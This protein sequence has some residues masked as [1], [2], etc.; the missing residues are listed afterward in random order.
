M[1]KRPYV[2]ASS[3]ALALAVTGCGGGGGASSNSGGGETTKAAQENQASDDSG[4]DQADNSGQEA[5]GSADRDISC[6]ITLATWDVAAAKT[7]DELDLEGRFQ[8]LYPNV[9]IDIEE[10]NAEPEYFNSMKIRS[11]AS[12][13]PDLMF[14]KSDSMNQY[15]E[16]L[17]DL[18]D[19]AANKD[20]QIASEYA[21]D[22]K[23]YGIPDRKAN[24]YVYYWTDLFEE[25][26]VSVPET[27]DEFVQVSETLQQHFGASD[28]EFAAICMGAKDAWPT[29]PL[30]EYGPASES[31]DGYYWDF[32]TTEDAPFAE[33]TAIR[34]VYTKIFNLF[35]KGVLGADPLGVT[36]DQ[37]RALFAKKKGAMVLNSPMFLTA[38]LADGYDPAGLETFYLPFRDSKDDPFNLVTQ[39][40]CFLTVTQH[41][42]NPEVARAF[43]EFYYSDAWYP[44]YIASISSDST[45]NS[46]PK[47]L[48]PVLQTASK[49]QPDVTF[50]TYGAGESDFI[51]MV[52][53]TK[54]D[55]KELGVEMLTEG[56]DLDARFDELDAVWTEAR[57]K[58][59]L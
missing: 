3:L 51:H 8:E 10:F 40:D 35:Q 7:F 33:G 39:G 1:K 12:E 26:G 2:L 18:T 38:Y 17:V 37:S 24:D 4:Q 5:A 41:S 13:L 30:M 48:D 28:P 16:Y 32:M 19:T 52:S 49:L 29:Y 20:N 11:S 31:G 54:F 42:E 44:D 53:E 23:V 43:L 22:G 21:I 14:H 58:L 50:V 9:T 6:T 57:S 55:C 46:F 59:G 47:E 34:T 36:Y 56:F 27:W 15:K 25:A 45:M